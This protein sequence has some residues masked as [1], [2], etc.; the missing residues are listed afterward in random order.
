MACIPTGGHTSSLEEEINRVVLLAERMLFLT[1][2]KNATFSKRKK[3]WHEPKHPGASRA[4][5]LWSTRTAF[6]N[7]R[8]SDCAVRRK[9]KKRWEKTE[10]KRDLPFFQNFRRYSLRRKN[11]MDGSFFCCVKRRVQKHDCKG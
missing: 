2:V 10:F 5:S 6:L 11:Y 1:S 8:I 9:A 4:N 3:D 7:A